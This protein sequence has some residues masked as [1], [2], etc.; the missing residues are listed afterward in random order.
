MA[1]AN[2]EYNAQ[3][4]GASTNGSRGAVATAAEQFYGRWSVALAED[5]P[6]DVPL[7]DIE[8]GRYLAQGGACLQAATILQRCLELSPNS[9]TAELDL[10]NCYVD[11]GLTDAAFA[12]INDMRKRSAGDP[13]ELAGVEALA[14]VSENKLA[15]ADRLLM[16]T[17][18]KYPADA[19]FAI[20][21]AELYREMGYRSL[22]QSPPRPSTGA[23][24]NLDPSTWFKKAL[25]VLDEGVQLSAATPGSRPEI[26][27]VNLRRMEMEKMITNGLAQKPDGKGQ[28]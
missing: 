22:R 18:A 17:K 4:R 23:T 9:V 16:E 20:V 21:M 27:L 3:L 26:E 1:R 24:T 13:L 12:L 14:Y 25:R 7:L 28:N 6:A 10:A 11:L 2:Q 5:G 19:R 15:E 8:I